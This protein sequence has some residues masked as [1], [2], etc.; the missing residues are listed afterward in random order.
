[1][2]THMETTSDAALMTTDEAAAR[3]GITS[4]ALRRITLQRGVLPDET[5]KRY[6]GGTFFLWAPRTIS[7]IAR[8]RETTEQLARQ[9][10]PQREP[11]RVDLLAAIFAVNRA[12]KRQ[13]DAAS[14]QYSHRQHGFARTASETKRHLYVLKDVGIAAAVLDGRLAYAGQH[15]RLA[16]YRGSGYCFHS[17][18]LPSGQPQVHDDDSPLI[19]REAK[20]REA[21]EALLRDAIFTL[22][23]IEDRT[24]EFDTMDLPRFR[25]VVADAVRVEMPDETG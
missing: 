8:L 25:P 16:V 18:L 22:E 11:V 2:A 7:R 13:R 10:K 1:M 9:A 3:L 14:K 24:D 6:G 15:A 19:M 12:A 21:K 20:P 4:I 23:Q 17:T 5:R